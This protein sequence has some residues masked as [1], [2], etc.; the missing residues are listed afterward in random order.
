MADG[1]AYVVKYCSN[2]TH[3]CYFVP[4]HN[5]R[6]HGYVPVVRELQGIAALVV[7]SLKCTLGMIAPVANEEMYFEGRVKLWDGAVNLIASP[8][9]WIGV[10]ILILRNRT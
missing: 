10:G 9:T 2:I 6:T 8:I 1:R 5:T 4:M 3:Q 7:G